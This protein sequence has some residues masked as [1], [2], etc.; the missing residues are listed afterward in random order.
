MDPLTAVMAFT[1]LSASLLTIADAA[2]KLSK[3]LYDIQRR[4]KKAPAKIQQLRQELKTLSELLTIIKSANDQAVAVP[5]ALQST[6]QSLAAQLEH[7][8]QELQ[9]ITDSSTNHKSRFPISKTLQIQMHHVL[10]ESTINEFHDRISKHV[11]YLTLMQSV[12][13]GYKADLFRDSTMDLLIETNTLMKVMS[14]KGKLL[15]PKLG[16]RNERTADG[17]IAIEDYESRKE[18]DFGCGRLLFRTFHIR[19]NGKSQGV[20]DVTFKLAFIPPAWLS[21]TCLQATI[22]LPSAGFVNNP[23]FSLRPVTINQHPELQ[24]VIFNTW[25]AD[26]LE[27]LFSTGLAR[28]TDLIIVPSIDEPTWLFEMFLVSM[29]MQ[30]IRRIDYGWEDFPKFSKMVSI[31][32]RD[33]SVSPIKA[34]IRILKLI[35]ASFTEGTESISPYLRLMLEHGLD[36]TAKYDIRNSDESIWYYWGVFSTFRQPYGQPIIAVL[37]EN[38]S[39]LESLKHMVSCELSHWTLHDLSGR[40]LWYIAVLAY[41]DPGFRHSLRMYLRAFESNLSKHHTRLREKHV[42]SLLDMESVFKQVEDADLRDRSIFLET[43]LKER[44]LN[45]IMPFITSQI[46]LDENSPIGNYLGIALNLGHIGSVCCLLKAGVNTAKAFQVF[47]YADKRFPDMGKD[48]E[49]I[50]L[51]YDF[52]QP[53][54]EISTQDGFPDPLTAFI[55]N[56]GAIDLRP[57]APQ[58][59]LNNGIYLESR[60]FGSQNTNFEESYIQSAI[61]YDKPAILELLLQLKPPL[62]D[63]IRTSFHFCSREESVGDFTW[64][65]FA[66]SLGRYKCVDVLLSHFE[67]SGEAVKKPDGAGRTAIQ[68]SE[69]AIDSSHPRYFGSHYRLDVITSLAEDKATLEVLRKHMAVED[70]ALGIDLSEPDPMHNCKELTIANYGYVYPSSFFDVYGVLETN[71]LVQF[72]LRKI[73]G[74]GAYIRCMSLQCNGDHSKHWAWRQQRR[75][76]IWLHKATFL[77]GLVVRG[78]YMVM[79][80]LVMI[81]DLVGIGLEMARIRQFRRPPTTVTVLFLVL[82]VVLTKCV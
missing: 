79:L 53:D 50:C 71:T 27:C 55:Q 16:S 56:Q 61:I 59:L 2:I 31:L 10:A 1:G 66:V 17:Q 32:L 13:N 38:I 54:V 35:A 14:S 42:D 4:F 57:D 52:L 58:T 21:N 28:P 41:A 39:G 68:V 80:L 7:D 51:L 8:L 40:S 11:A 18:F 48:V 46:D 6:L 81:L 64:L 36:L 62:W 15:P 29:Q 33:K 65:T 23:V 82:V 3:T 75:S 37:V 22:E 72:S 74:L 60:L 78:A 19:S 44:L 45:T 26:R 47:K 70:N 49:N 25:D 69:T 73:P 12:L 5:A 24:D 30:M 9:T 77:E 67:D 63:T 34:A 43:I 20:E 76:L